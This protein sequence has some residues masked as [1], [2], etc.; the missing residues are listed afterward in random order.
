[1]AFSLFAPFLGVRIRLERWFLCLTL[2]LYSVSSFSHQRILHQNK[3]NNLLYPSLLKISTK[4]KI[5]NKSIQLRTYLHLA[6]SSWRAFGF[7]SQWHLA[8]D[9]WSQ[10]DTSPSSAT[11]YGVQGLLVLLG[12]PAAKQLL[13]R[14]L[15]LHSH[16]PAFRT[17]P[18]GFQ[19]LQHECQL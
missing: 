9:K 11:F 3:F 1:M 12:D 18:M 2:V 5:K 4:K 14:L 13:L 16:S 17:L 7:E 8:S 10:R 6:L 15:L 19:L